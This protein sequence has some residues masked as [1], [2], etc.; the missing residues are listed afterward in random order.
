MSR[1]MV[2]SVVKTNYGTGDYLIVNA[3]EESTEPSFLD[4]V[5]G[6]TSSK[7][8]SRPHRNFRCETFPVKIRGNFYLNGYDENLNTVW[9]DNRRLIV[10]CEETLLLT[11]S[12]SGTLTF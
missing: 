9:G 1:N 4:T 12:C 8:F 6:R 5:N 7:Y 11:M 3:S 2:G 10:C